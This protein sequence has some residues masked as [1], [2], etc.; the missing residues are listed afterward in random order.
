MV[1]RLC[2]L[3]ND[4]VVVKHVCGNGKV[5]QEIV[6]P[7][8]LEINPDILQRRV[9]LEHNKPDIRLDAMFSEYPE[10]PLVLGHRSHFI[11]S[12]EGIVL[13]AFKT[14]KDVAKTCLHQRA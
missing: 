4:L 8:E 6:P 7:E 11:H 10:R 14:D 1:I 9:R 5:F 2:S 12:P 13:P 3:K